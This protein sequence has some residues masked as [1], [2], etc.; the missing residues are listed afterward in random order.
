MRCRPSYPGLPNRVS[1][2]GRTRFRPPAALDLRHCLGGHLDRRHQRRAGR[3]AVRF[4]RNMFGRPL[5]PAAVTEASTERYVARARLRRRV[6][7][8]RRARAWASSSAA[9]CA[10]RSSSLTSRHSVERRAP[11]RRTRPAASSSRNSAS[12]RS[13]PAPAR[14]AARARAQPR[15]GVRQKPLERPRVDRHRR[16]PGARGCTPAWFPRDGRR[17]ISL[18]CGRRGVAV[19]PRGR[20]GS[21]CRR[22]SGFARSA[23]GEWT[24]ARW[25]G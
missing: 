14:S 3:S 4:E 11:L 10:I 9:R 24:S 23:G 17:D 7:S 2:E 21:H 13:Y 12:T 5:R 20:G 15:R 16:A 19:I 18:R 25:C 1:S 6:G 22:R 8:S